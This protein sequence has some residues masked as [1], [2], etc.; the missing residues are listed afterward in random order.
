MDSMV[1]YLTAWDL[2]LINP[3]TKRNFKTEYGIYLH[4][5]PQCCGSGMFI[6]DPTCFHPGSEFFHPGSWIR[7]KE[8]KYFN[9]TKWFPSSRK[10]DPGCSSRFRI[11]LTF[12]PSRIPDPQ[13]CLIIIIRN[14]LLNKMLTDLIP[15]PEI[16]QD[17]SGS[18]PVSTKV[19]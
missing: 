19:K 16:I 10:Y 7:I 4:P 2:I 17:L 3:F 13:H 6:P 9:P 12:Y 1:R 8:L 14:I 18:G 11:I 15:I 5:C